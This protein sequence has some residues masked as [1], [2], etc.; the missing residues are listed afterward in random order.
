MSKQ[1]IVELNQQDTDNVE[2]YNDADYNVS[3]KKSITIEKGDQIQLKS[4]FI[5]TRIANSQKIELKGDVLENGSISSQTTISIDFGYYKSDVRGTFETE[6]PTES[7]EGEFVYNFAYPSLRTGR[8]MVAFKE[9]VN[10][11]ATLLT[12]SEIEIILNFTSF[13]SSGNTF[14][15]TL[16]N[17]AGKLIPYTFI[18]KKGFN[19][20]IT[21]DPHRDFSVFTLTQPALDSIIHSDLCVFTWDKLPNFQKP[22]PPNTIDTILNYKSN[23]RVLKSISTTPYVTTS[24]KTVE[25]YI[26]NI[27]FKLPSGLYDPND[28]AELI[29]SKCV[30]V[31]LDGD[32]S[33]KSYELTRNPLLKSI[34]QI[35]IDEN[36]QLEFIDIADGQTPRKHIYAT[37]D[38]TNGNNALLNYVIGSS[39]FGLSY[40]ETLQKMEFLQLHNSLF[41]GKFFQIGEAG[42]DP[43]KIGTA[44]EQTSAPEIRLI[45]NSSAGNQALDTKYMVN[46]NCGIYLTN[47]EP[48]SLWFDQMKFDPSIQV[49]LK[50][51]EKTFINSG[52]YTIHAPSKLDESSQITGDESG[53]DETIIKTLNAQIDTTGGPAYVTGGFK[54]FDIVQAIETGDEIITNISQTRT[55]LAKE[56]LGESISNEGGYYKIEIGMNGIRSDLRGFGENNKI[57]SIISKFYSQ[58][59]FTSSYSEGSIPYVHLSNEP[60]YINDFQV[61]ILDPDNKLSRNIG[62]NNSIF[63]EI[64]KV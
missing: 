4:C 31:D 56:S 16:P 61:R 55:I 2:V 17:E 29:N 43:V 15:F 21:K 1:I 8:P 23:Q 63:L 47:L 19:S 18:L 49:G 59:S 48:K 7:T 57:Q 22:V 44:K 27:T 3:L 60:L 51:I 13:S 14:S 33:S 40:N 34:Q 28:V 6:V 25:P 45:R 39:Q 52:K 12:C 64:V 58:N 24:A 35:R 54:S 41:S 46:K 5:D 37:G 20:F 30:E 42:V 38:G 26:S 62:E 10:P 36:Q 53:L 9:V 11:T 50:P 32:L